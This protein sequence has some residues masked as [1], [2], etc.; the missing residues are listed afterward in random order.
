MTNEEAAR[1]L[2][3]KTTPEALAEIEYYGVFEGEKAKQAA[4]YDAC[5]LAAAALRAQAEAERNDPLTLEEL[6][7]MGGEPVWISGG[8]DDDIIVN[9]YGAVDFKYYNPENPVIWWIGGELES[10][11]N[12]ENYGKTWMAYRRKKEETT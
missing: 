11:P 5:E 1:I 10:V 6:R 2:D 7:E 9:A 3:P 12:I 4:V 8:K